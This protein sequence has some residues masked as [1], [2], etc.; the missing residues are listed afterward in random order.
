MTRLTHGRLLKTIKVTLSANNSSKKECEYVQ[1]KVTKQLP[2]RCD[3]MG[4][5]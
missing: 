1:K 5:A 4:Q 3:Y 2:N